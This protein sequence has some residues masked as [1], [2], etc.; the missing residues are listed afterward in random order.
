VTVR[1]IREFG[2]PVLR[3]PAQP[4]TRFDAGLARLVTDLLETCRPPGRAGLAAPQIGVGLRV[5]SYNMDG[6]EGYLVNPRLVSSD[7]HQDG[8]EGCLSIPGLYLPVPRAEHAVVIGADLTGRQIEVE[9]TGHFARCLQHELDHLDGQLYLG[10]LSA[11]DRRHALSV[12][13]TRQMAVP[14]DTVRLSRCARAL[15][16]VPAGTVKMISPLPVSGTRWPAKDGSWRCS[17]GIVPGIPGEA[18]AWHKYRGI[19]RSSWSRRDRR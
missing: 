11:S 8:P 15:R 1:A 4:V 6:D 13:R 9:G 7:G 12:I 5:F 16:Q 19:S 3:E 10:R 18:D 2:D 17:S 14:R